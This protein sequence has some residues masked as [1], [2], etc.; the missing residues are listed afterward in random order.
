V[1]WAALL[2][3]GSAAWAG[4]VPFAATQAPGPISPTNATLN[5]M[6]VPNGLPTL[7]W[8][9]WGTNA[10]LTQP[11]PPVAV[12][13][14]GSVQRLSAAVTGLS[15]HA[16]YHC[17]LVASNAAGI[18]Q[19][20]D[21]RFTTGMRV[22]GWGSGYQGLNSVP[23]N[24]TNAVA[25]AGGANLSLALKSDGTVDEWGTL[26]LGPPRGLSNVVAVSAAATRS[27]ALRADGGVV[28]WGNSFGWST[29]PSNVVAIALGQSTYYMLRADGTIVGY[30]WLPSPA[31]L[32]NVV[33]VGAGSYFGV[34][35]RAEGTVLAW[36]TD[37]Y[38]ATNVPPGLSNVVAIACG[39]SHVLAL[40]G[41]GRVVAWGPNAAAQCAVPADLTNVVAISAGGDASLALKGD[42]SLVA[43]GQYTTDMRKPPAW[44][45][46]AVAI[47]SGGYFDLALADRPPTA[48]PLSVAAVVNQ[49]TVLTLAGGDPDGDALGF[50]I[51]EWPA[52]GSLF[53]YTTNGRGAPLGLTNA[54]VADA[55]GRL[56]LVAATGGSTNPLANLAFVAHDGNADSLPATVAIQT[57]S[58]PL[59][60]TQA[61]TPVHATGATL[62]GMVTPNTWPTVAWFEYGHTTDYGQTTTPVAVGDGSGV[63]HT[64]AE[65]SGLAP[66]EVYHCRVTATNLMGVSQGRDQV[67]T[68]GRKVAVWGAN[69]NG[70]TELPEELHEA[71]VISSG[72]LHVLAFTATGVVASWGD[73]RFGATSVPPDL[74]NATAIAGC[75]LHSL[76]T[77][78]DGTVVGWG[79]N[80]YRQLDVPAGVS[81]VVGLAGGDGHSVA[82][83]EDGTVVAWGNNSL[84]QS[85]VPAGL[86]NVVAIA[87][88]GNHTLALKNNG[89]VVAWGDPAIGANTLPSGVTNVVA[90]AAGFSHCL[91]LRED[92]TVA[93]WGGAAWSVWPIAPPAG[94]SNVVAIA[95]GVFHS[96]A[97]KSDGSVVAW[98]DNDFGQ[99]TVPL[100]LR[101]V[102]AISGGEGYTVVL[103]VNVPPQTSSQNVTSTTNQPITI[104]LSA[105]DVNSDPLTLRITGRPLQGGLFQY[106]TNGP[107]ERILAADTPVA[108]AQHRVRF[109]PDVDAAGSPYAN[110]SFVANDGEADSVPGMVTVHIV[111]PPRLEAFGFYPVAGA[112]ELNFTG[113]P[114]AAY[115]VWTTTNLVNWQA[116]GAASEDPPGWF[117]F[118][119]AAATNQ[120][121]RF[122]RVGSP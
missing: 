89:R 44:L 114:S 66:G 84:G 22:R 105:S 40:K 71:T 38:G 107:G 26:D 35:L 62:H 80:A 13:D 33:A 6:V 8:F 57:L 27:L 47:A 14:G 115:R 111:P 85:S 116:L 93:A 32:S 104:P 112:F 25:I 54:T 117:H 122:Y 55:K 30:F 29:G 86:S 119:D 95:A 106:T 50:R 76:A 99:A 19:G 2:L 15:E 69:W 68:T 10:D 43:W 102:L 16:V 3:F 79:A 17:R 18:R 39:T 11:T 100:G 97:L 28:A 67:F 24:L 118:S 56:I 103:A 7:A 77:R 72:D 98:G 120:P 70:Q 41:D 20:W 4:T 59:A 21:Q 121:R 46:N 73:S 52:A 65:I 58:Q 113:V 34:A 83:K 48:D 45:T 64:A 49:E 74:S 37:H 42:G 9:E 108:D 96:L 1:G 63:T 23:P 101:D 91:A 12:G 5:G 75:S 60:F 88:R 87:A 36:G 78:P 82:L 31:G 51:V 110:F 90:I 109:V 61:T 92:G 53:Q 94:L 81:N